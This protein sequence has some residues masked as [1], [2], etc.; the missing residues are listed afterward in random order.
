MSI[1][2]PDLGQLPGALA[3]GVA[4]T[5]AALGQE[6]SLWGQFSQL[7]PSIS[8]SAAQVVKSPRA[9]ELYHPRPVLLATG[10]RSGK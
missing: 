8:N 5:Q 2:S 9:Q 3:M 7:F 10:Y 6:P 4:D 1:S